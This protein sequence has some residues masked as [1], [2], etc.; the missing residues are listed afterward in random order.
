MKLEYDGGGVYKCK[1]TVFKAGPA[2]LKVSLKEVTLGADLP[3]ESIAGASPFEIVITLAVT[4]PA[5][6]LGSGDGR[7][8]ELACV[9]KKRGTG[10]V[11][12]TKLLLMLRDNLQWPNALR[13]RSALDL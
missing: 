12:G 10:R 6:S 5:N 13:W 9:T 8:A 1:F 4:D 2:V 3:P 11:C 7:R